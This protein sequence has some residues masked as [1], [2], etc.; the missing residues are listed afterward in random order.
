MKL[1]DNTLNYI[2][3][4]IDVAKKVSIESL[5]ITAENIRGLDEDNS[6]FLFQE[7]DIPKME[8]DAIGISKSDEFLLRL[9][10]VKND[11]FS[12]NADIDD[13]NG[14][15]RNLTFKNDDASSYTSAS[16]RCAN[17][18]HVQSPKSIRNKNTITEIILPDKTVDK[19]SLAVGSMKSNDDVVFY[20]DEDGLHLNMTDGNNDV[21]KHTFKREDNKDIFNHKYS[22]KMLLTALKL[23]SNCTFT[24][25]ENGMLTFKL[26]GISLYILPK[27]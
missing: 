7:T 13:E 17:P 8:F 4:T 24:L 2:E 1:S 9:G 15:V 22:V 3:K 27:L 26:E 16:Y 19:L 10:I 25:M 12:V 23:D 6:I 18:D 21:F 5:A 20:G 11:P 14:F